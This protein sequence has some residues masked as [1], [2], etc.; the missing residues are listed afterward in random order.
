MTKLR[1][2]DGIPEMDGD[3]DEIV[4]IL[5]K[6]GIG[7]QATQPGQPKKKVERSDLNVDDVPDALRI[8]KMIEQGGPPFTF[9]IAELGK[10][11][12]GRYIS[13]KEDR[14]FYI[15]YY[16]MCNEAKKLMQKKYGGRWDSKTISIEDHAVKRYLLIEETKT[17]PETEVPQTFITQSQL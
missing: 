11:L 8:M 9:S 7:L 1:L 3:P 2:V 6:L 10:K 14:D 17:E 13:S 12:F 16:R 15:K 4:E 5:R